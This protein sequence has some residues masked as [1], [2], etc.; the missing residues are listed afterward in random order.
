MTALDFIRF[1]K[2]SK[3]ASG[4]M[5][6]TFE[7]QTFVGNVP[8]R[9]IRTPSP[10]GKRYVLPMLIATLLISTSLQL[11][12]ANT[13]V[14]SPQTAGKAQTARAIAE[15]GS[16][17]LRH[18]ERLEDLEYSP[19]GS[20]L[21]AVS[22][23]GQV[24]LWSPVSGDLVSAFSH[25]VGDSIFR[26]SYLDAQTVL[27]GTGENRLGAL[28][29]NAGG[30]LEAVSLDGFGLGDLQDSGGGVAVAPNGEYLCQWLLGKGEGI[31]LVAMPKDGSRGKRSILN[32][33]GFRV[34][35]VVWAPGGELLAVLTT[36]PLKSLG[37]KGSEDQDCSRILI[38]DPATGEE[39][40]RLVSKDKFL[41][42]M[43]FALTIG[44]TAEGLMVTGSQEGFGVW[45]LTSGRMLSAFGA[46]IG[47]VASLDARDRGDGSSDVIASSEEGFTQGWRVYAEAAPAKISDLP[48]YGSLGRITIHPRLDRLQFASVESR[49]ISQWVQNSGENTWMEDPY[50]PRH[51]GIVS[52]L[53]AA[54]GRLASAGYDG[55]VYLWDYN[56]GEDGSAVVHARTRLLANPNPQSL[57][58]DVS[59]SSDGK[60]M[61]SS[62]RDGVLREWNLRDGE[63]G[64]GTQIGNWVSDTM[65]SFTAT[66]LSP[67]GKLMTSVSADQVLWVRDALT[68]DLIR[69]F[70]AL[71]GLDFA[72]SFSADGRIFAV[73]SSGAR[74]YNTETWEEVRWIKD[75]GAPIMDLSMS[76]N[77]KLIAIAT[78]AN[79]LVIRDVET[80]GLI[81]AW[82]NFRGRPSG[83]CWVN[84][85]VLV[86]SGPNEAGFRI[87]SIVDAEGT[88]GQP[89]QKVDSPHGGDVQALVVLPS[90]HVASAASDGFLHIW[91]I[92]L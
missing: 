26:V 21:A 18:K 1:P 41:T 29:I 76:P 40:I 63:E 70:E 28:H 87:L 23:D 49:T 91:D 8:S 15:F 47:R 67:D 7:S 78:A 45:D 20:Q 75:L 30:A 68:G 62:G 55:Y 17:G 13:P 22:V 34:S 19:D 11:N 5:P 14:E 2:P 52:A 6:D 46:D 54:P 89:G 73:G 37:R 43:D 84:D 9:S 66:D 80:G 61:A 3:C 25:P 81:S 83:V 42:D 10:H 85:R 71:A 56:L 74:I 27:Y 50:L 64:F 58:T 48:E 24:N 31:Q 88:V 51:E 44:G 86:A 90:G 59:L 36:N 79:S 77:G 72:S 92:G 32:A 69:K 4:Y 12:A 53:A 35:Q 38:V 33:D 60:I 39:V 82:T 57:V 16:S 65:A